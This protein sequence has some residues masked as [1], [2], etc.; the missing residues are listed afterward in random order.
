MRNGDMNFDCLDLRNRV[1]DAG[2]VQWVYAQHPE[3][4]RGARRLN[5]TIDRKNTRS[6]KGDALVANVDVVKC[7]NDG[8]SAALSILKDS[9]IFSNDELDIELIV[10]QEPG[11]DMLRPYRVEVGVLSG[12]RAS[13]DIVDLEE[14]KDDED[15]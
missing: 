14:E 11:V 4:E 8:K 6:W 13:H 3:W 12:D 9:S 10:Q 2:L 7:W 15:N 1:G 5:T